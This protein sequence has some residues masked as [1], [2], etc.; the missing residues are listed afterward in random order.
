MNVTLETARQVEEGTATLETCRA[1]I[2]H[3][4]ELADG[5]PTPPDWIMSYYYAQRR[6]WDSYDENPLR[7]V[8]DLKGLPQPRD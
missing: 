2:E 4:W 7:A 3:V 8:A 1:L 6:V 5:G